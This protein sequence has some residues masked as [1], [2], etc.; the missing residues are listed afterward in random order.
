[1]SVKLGPPDSSTAHDE[2][3]IR[4]AMN[5]YERNIGDGARCSCHDDQVEYVLTA[6]VIVPGELRNIMF[7]SMNF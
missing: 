4:H 1:M 5:A 3:V 2:R 6:H 7:H